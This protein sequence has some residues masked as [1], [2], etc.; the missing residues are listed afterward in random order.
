MV[1]N[2]VQVDL[3][4]SGYKIQPFVIPAA[5]V[6]APHERYRVWF[7]AYANKIGLR[8]EE[9]IRELGRERFSFDNGG[10]IWQEF[11]TQFPVCN[12]NDGLSARLDAITFSKWRNESIKAGGNAIVP[13]IVFNIFKSIKAYEKLSSMPK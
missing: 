4:N 5:G 6:N 1:F 10:D 8:S 2:E 9:Q 13:Q 11:P 7:V 12:G 3:E